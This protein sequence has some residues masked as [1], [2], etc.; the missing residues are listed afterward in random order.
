MFKR[1]HYIALGLVILLTLVVLKLPNRAVSQLELAINGLFLPMFGLKGTAGGLA[2]KAT[3]A[4]VPRKELVGDLEQLRVEN[5]ELR[6]Q[7]TQMEES[8][9]ENHRLR[10]YLNWPKPRDWKLKL[11]RVIARDPANWWRTLK[12]DTGLREGVTTNCPVLSGDGYLV[13][14]VSDVAY[15][16]SQVVL[17]GDP[18]CR[19]SVLIE[20]ARDNGIIAPSSSRP[21][22][23]SIVDLVYL[24]RNSPLRSGQKVVTSGMGGVFPKGIE[25]GQ[26]VDWRTVGYGLYNEARVSLAVNMNKLEEVWVILP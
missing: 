8:A 23:N 19:V 22:D 21:L 25:V 6:L 10:K 12:I 3:Q 14:R 24:S 1:S 7:V 26:I 4:V 9:R 15:T 11:A 2:E 18:D 13:G 5:Q 20:E 17:L 16:Q